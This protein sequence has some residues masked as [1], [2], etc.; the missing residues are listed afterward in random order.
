MEVLVARGEFS[1]VIAGPGAAA[2]PR[3]GPLA[4]GRRLCSHFGR[5]GALAG[6]IREE[7][8]PAIIRYGDA[9]VYTEK[10]DDI[11]APPVMLALSPAAERAHSAVQAAAQAFLSHFTATIHERENGMIAIPNDRDSFLNNAETLE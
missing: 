6:T 4:A 2:E 7:L 3:L 5:A 1:I 10:K 11:D 9:L 8:M